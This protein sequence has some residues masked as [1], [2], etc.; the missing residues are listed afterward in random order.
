MRATGGGRDRRRQTKLK[1]SPLPGGGDGGTVH[2]RLY[3]G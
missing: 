1:A 3:R 2:L